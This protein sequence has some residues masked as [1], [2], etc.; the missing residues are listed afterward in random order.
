MKLQITKE[1]IQKTIEDI[2]NSYSKPNRQFILYCFD[3]RGLEMFDKAIK[4]EA[5][6][7]YNETKNNIT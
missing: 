6:K 1:E 3:E 2:Y 5:K 7:Q 4:E